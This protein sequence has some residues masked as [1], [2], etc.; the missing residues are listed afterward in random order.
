M[1][2]ESW[3]VAG[4]RA[5]LRKGFLNYLNRH[6]PDIL[7]LQEIKAKP[8]QVEDQ[9]AKIKNYE[10]YLNPAERKGYSGTALLTKIH[11]KKVTC[12][13]G[14]KKFDSEGR[15]IIAD[16]GK[17]YLLNVYA[18]QGRRDK[19][20]VPF[21][22]EFYKELL[23]KVKRLRK[24]VIMCGD[25]NTAHTEIDLAR[26]KANKDNTGFLPEEREWID[27]IIAAGFIDTFRHFNKE[28]GHYTFWDLKTRARERNVGWRVDYI[29]IDKELLPHLKKAYILSKVY[30]SDHCPVGIEIN[31]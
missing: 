7:C 12:G 4:L 6:K 23:N 3:N 25:F 21:K 29:F 8:E 30:G 11:P 5:V 16:Y 13:L 22:L 31:I 20:R 24:P 9:L 26:P 14:I 27:K 10:I 18:P 2:I 17:F 28:P 1:K 15:L 19:S